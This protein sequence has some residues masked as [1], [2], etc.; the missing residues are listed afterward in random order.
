MARQLNNRSKYGA[1]ALGLLLIVVLGA[2]S[3]NGG[4][5]EPAPSIT[6]DTAQWPATFGFGKPATPQQIAAWDI[7]VRPD[8]LGLP[9]GAGTVAQG[10]IIY[11]AKCAACH[12]SAEKVVPG[13]KLPAPV[14]VSDSASK[15]KAI[16]NYWPY[17]ST[18]FDYI[19]RS[20]PYNLPGSLTDNEVYGVTAYI[21][22]ANKILKPDA[23]LNAQ[24]LPRIVMPAQKLYINDDR[25]GGPEVR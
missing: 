24:T 25:R 12:G 2:Y 20:M 7:D 16:G 15:V 23:V 21:L 9:V 8:G 17:A 11:L 3:Y 14:L 5:G 1:I 10:K 13:V 18:V 4:V 22:N 6:A 19:R